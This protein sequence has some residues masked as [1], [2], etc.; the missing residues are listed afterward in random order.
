[1]TLVVA[2]SLACH[3]V[4]NINTMRKIP[5]TMVTQ[6]PDNA[7]KA[8]WLGKSFIDSREEVRECFISYLE[9]GCEEF[10]WDWEGKYVDEAVIERLFEKNLSFFKENS[11]GKDIFLTYRFPNIWIEKG[12]YRIL[13]A[14]VN[15]ITA[16]D[17]AKDIGL[18]CPPIFEVILPMV[19]QAEQLIYIQTKF[20]E[21]SHLVSMDSTAKIGSGNPPT[22]EIIPL[23][24]DIPHLLDI[25]KLLE[26]YVELY[27]KNGL[28]KIKKLEYIRP[29]IAR[30]DPALNYGLVP[31]VLAAKIALSKSHQVSSKL[32]IKVYPIIGCGT[33]PFR[34][35]LSPE[36]IKNFLKEYPG[37][38]TVTI[39]S[40]FRYDHPPD[41]VKKAIKT[42]NTKLL[43]PDKMTLI[44]SKDLKALE[45]IIKVFKTYYRRDI[46]KIAGLINETAKFVPSRRERRLHI[47]LFGYSREFTRGVHFPRAIT[48]TCSL[49]S[50]GIPPEI[51]G[52]G[53]ALK[54]I[55][56]KGLGEVLERHY[57]NLRWDLERS[58]RFVNRENIKRLKKKYPNLKD[59]EED[60]K[61]IENTLKVSTEPQTSSHIVHKRLTSNILLLL[62]KK[63]NPTML[64]EEAGTLRGFLG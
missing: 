33:V 54:I 58:C 62:K 45:E 44:E 53:R 25:D 46:T 12:S 64:I 1:M 28:A 50:L 32:G 5:R 24:E 30:S 13:R 49:Y 18:H 14:F 26:K 55:Q 52:A 2:S 36:N 56:K 47:G 57:T 4:K 21:L 7:G 19:T 43:K 15:I 35:H 59:I 22:V 40:S 34:G 41:R 16:Y 20:T 48:F 31:A 17:I 11:L 29:F 27:N 61:I 9:L 23:I 39:Q 51:I 63:E 6:H 37:I 38:K 3:N 10:M 60:L 8:F 42:L